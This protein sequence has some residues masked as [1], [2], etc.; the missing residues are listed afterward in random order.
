MTARRHFVPR[1]AGQLVVVASGRRAL[2]LRRAVSRDGRATLVVAIFDEE[3]GELGSITLT[4]GP[5]TMLASALAKAV[6]W[7]YATEAPLDDPPAPPSAPTAAGAEPSRVVEPVRAT[8]RA[9]EPVRRPGEPPS[10]WIAAERAAR[11]GGSR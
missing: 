3:R 4:A 6:A 9:E 8:H 2:E 5:G 11:P 10:S 7:A 1:R